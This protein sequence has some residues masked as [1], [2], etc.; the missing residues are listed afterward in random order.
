AAQAAPVAIAAPPAE[1]AALV[2]PAEPAISTR[3]RIET[4]PRDAEIVLDDAV[5]GNPFD[6][7]F[8][9]SEL[10]HRM[11][12]R[13][14]GYKTD[15]RWVTFDDDQTLVI[16]LEKDGVAEAKPVRASRPAKTTVA[17]PAV[18]KPPTEISKPADSKPATTA[19]ATPGA[20]ATYKGTKGSIITEYPPE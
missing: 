15:S 5:V 17:V 11:Q 6:G 14:P 12:V 4:V 9:R 7:R 8:S 19:P 16:T 18:T 20:K 1:P 10:R 3:L 2:A 13:A